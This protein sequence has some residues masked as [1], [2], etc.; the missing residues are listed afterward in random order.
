MNTS[1]STLGVTDDYEFQE[2]GPP[3]TQSVPVSVQAI[4][5]VCMKMFFFVGGTTAWTD[6]YF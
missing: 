5:G 6:T 2:Q 3:E 4:A 1:E